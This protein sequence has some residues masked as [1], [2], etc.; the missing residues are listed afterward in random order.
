MGHDH[1]SDLELELPSSTSRAVVW[2]AVVL[3]LA[4][5]VGMFVLWPDGSGREQFADFGYTKEYR[6]AEVI[7]A[8][9]EPCESIPEGYSTDHP[10][11][12]TYV[13]RVLDGPDAGLEITQELFDAAQG[14]RFSVGEM[15]VLA[16][17]PSVLEVPSMVPNQTVERSA[18]YSVADRNRRTELVWLALLFAVVVVAL[19]RWRGLAA[20][21][22]LA[23]TIVL[24]LVFTLPAIIDGRDALAVAIVSASAIAFCA[25]YLAHG[26]TRLTT[27]A[28]L[29]TLAALVLTAVLASLFTTVTRL[30]GFASE[31]S[32]FLT[33]GGADISISGL[34]LAGIVIGALGAIDD[35]TVTQV[36]SVAELHR[37]NPE[38]GFRDLYKAAN[39]IGQDHVAST[40]NTLV[41][42]YAGA[43]MPLLVLLTVT[44][45][46]LGSVANGELIATEIVRTLVGS[47]GL[48]AAVPITTLLAALVVRTG[49]VHEADAADLADL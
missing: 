46:A 1:Q 37:A 22:G 15:V 41:L 12:A 44:D 5:L 32:A 9:E 2:V 39:R 14:A 49:R 7:S 20:L 19:G 29:G 40:V 34:V 10:I 18:A 43:S 48:V 25:I 6:D 31:E 11:C 30:T 26:F 16:F 8:L 28:V 21:A 47:I 4:T 24:L 23:A 13:L 35:M 42:A 27:V 45:Q 38:F 17:N 3:G 33:I 36:S